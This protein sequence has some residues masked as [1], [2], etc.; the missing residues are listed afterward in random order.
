[1]FHILCDKLSDFRPTALKSLWYSLRFFSFL[2][3]F[4]GLITSC[5]RVIQTTPQC[6]VGQSWEKHVRDLGRR[7]HF[8]NLFLWIDSYLAPSPFYPAS[9]YWINQSA[10]LEEETAFPVR[11]E[12]E[13]EALKAFWKKT[14]LFSYCRCHRRCLSAVVKASGLSPWIFCILISL[15]KCVPYLVT[16]V[17]TLV[18]C[19]PSGLNIFERGVEQ[20][21]FCNHFYS[22]HAMIEDFFFFNVIPLINFAVMTCFWSCQWTCC[23]SAL[24]PWELLSHTWCL[25]PEHKPNRS[26]VGL[27]LVAEGHVWARWKRWRL[28]GSRYRG[29][30]EL[31]YFWG[32]GSCSHGPWG[33]E[34][35]WGAEAHTDVRMN[36]QSWWPCGFPAW[37]GGRW[38]E[39]HPVFLQVIDST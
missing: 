26:E 17:S 28:T 19:P 35:Q 33:E 11:W 14:P 8:F 4:S 7:N 29:R 2:H 20:A 32:A 15:P 5:P 1:M 6:M 34:V 25:G 36:A 38:E 9:E 23:I 21:S 37:V 24:Y 10:I 31:W 39:V 3:P 16:R 22:S 12:E 30:E 18:S 13:R 27:K